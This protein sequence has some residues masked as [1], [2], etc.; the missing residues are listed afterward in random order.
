MKP[1]R[2]FIGRVYGTHDH[3]VKVSTKPGLWGPGPASALI[4]LIC[5]SYGRPE[6]SFII[7]WFIFC[8]ILKEIKKD[9]SSL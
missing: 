9:S 8:I 1:W 3:P 7:K 4:L 6:T 5:I 2:G